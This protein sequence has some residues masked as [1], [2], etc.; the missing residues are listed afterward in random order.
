MKKSSKK[1]PARKTKK[2]PQIKKLPPYAGIREYL[3]KRVTLFCCRYIYHGTLT[4][5]NGDHLE[6][7]NGT[8]VYETGTFDKMGWSV[9]EP[10]PPV[11]NV[12]LQSVESF[13]LLKDL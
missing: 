7:R 8:I 3:G 1:A 13:G 4:G 6:L 9:S 10:L 12:N 5:I 11:W 2:L